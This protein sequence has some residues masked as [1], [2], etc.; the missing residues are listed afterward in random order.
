MQR[1]WVVG[2]EYT[3]T[4]FKTLAPGTREERH[5]PFATYADAAKVWAGRTWATVD[6]ATT[7]FRIVSE[8]T[9]GAP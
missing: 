8:D 2:G 6:S 5:G 4:D 7:R 1:Y 3:D 9:G